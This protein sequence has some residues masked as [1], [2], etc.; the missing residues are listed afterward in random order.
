VRPKEKKN[1]NLEDEDVA[2]TGTIYWTNLSNSQ[3]QTGKVKR[4]KK[5]IKLKSTEEERRRAQKKEKAK[6][7]AISRTQVSPCPKD[8]APTRLSRINPRK[9]GHG[10]DVRKIARIAARIGS[11]ASA[12]PR[13]YFL[14]PPLV[15]VHA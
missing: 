2:K 1:R 9:D 5:E 8:D 4:G 10:Q 12:P 15:H 7:C 6:T 13:S 14:M 11:R 3:E